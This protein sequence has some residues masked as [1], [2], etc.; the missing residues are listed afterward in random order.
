MTTDRGKAHGVALASW[1]V[2]KLGESTV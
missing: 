2:G 1:E